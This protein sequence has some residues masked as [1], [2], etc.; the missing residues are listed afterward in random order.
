MEQNP[1]SVP[2]LYTKPPPLKKKKKKPTD[3]MWGMLQG[4]GVLACWRLSQAITKQTD[5]ILPLEQ[6][7]QLTSSAVPPEP[8]SSKLV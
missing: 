6:R 5:E 7:K 1:V 3:E 8:L 2:A 4:S